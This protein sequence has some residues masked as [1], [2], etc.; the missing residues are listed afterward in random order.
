MTT[1]FE[2]TRN[3]PNKNEYIKNQ[4]EKEGVS[5]VRTKLYVGDYTFSDNQSICIDT[6]AGMGEIESN[7][8]HDHERFKSE[9]VRAKEAGISLIILICDDKINDIS[10]VFSWR[11]PRR[12]YSKQA[13]TGRTLGKIMYSMREKYG[14]SFEFATKEQMGKRI[15]ELLGGVK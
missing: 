1:V 4:L 2:D 3:K 14:V 12:I 13:T 8:V 11:N 7:L 10:Q 5:V 6:K 15:L 9:C